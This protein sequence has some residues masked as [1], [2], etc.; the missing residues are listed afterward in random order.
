[1]T[2]W[3]DAQLSP[4]LATWITTT[5]GIEAFSV[6][7]LGL[8]DAND[9]TIFQAAR[10]ANAVVMTKDS[11]FLDLQLKLGV[12]PQIILVSIGNS[13]NQRMREVLQKRWLI[14]QE[15]LETGEPVVELQD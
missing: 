14:I 9:E 4:A 12:P 11:D 1:M 3:I 8:R 2:I 7:F 10:T 13:S 15:F 5:F 6:A